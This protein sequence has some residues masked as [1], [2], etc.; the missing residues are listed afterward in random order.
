MMVNKGET[1]KLRVDVSSI[2]SKARKI[3]EIHDI[4]V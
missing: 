3:Y 2:S 1:L 4:G